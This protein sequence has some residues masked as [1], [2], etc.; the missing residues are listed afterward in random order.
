[1]P[2]YKAMEVNVVCVLCRCK[3]LLIPSCLARV[4]TGSVTGNSNRDSG[5]GGKVAMLYCASIDSVGSCPKT[6]PQEQRG[7]TLYALVSRLQRQ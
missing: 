1:M 4:V 2:P 5:L 6:D 7:L 3:F